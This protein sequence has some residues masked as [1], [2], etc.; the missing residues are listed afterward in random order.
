MVWL[1]TLAFV[2]QQ[3]PKGTFATDPCG[4]PTTVSQIYT[5]CDAVVKDVLDGRTVVVDFL[6]P[7]AV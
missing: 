1:L 6:R 2:L 3:I 4:D 7:C 5:S